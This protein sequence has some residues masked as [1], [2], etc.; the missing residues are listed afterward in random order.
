ML[1]YLDPNDENQLCIGYSVCHKNDRFDYR[2][3]FHLNGIGIQFAINKADKHKTSS[4]FII[5]TR[6]EDRQLPKTIV[7]I[8]QSI[9][10]SLRHF[11]Y[12]C[13][14][15]KMYAGKQFP[16]WA[17]NFANPDFGPYKEPELLDEVA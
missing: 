17:I 9:A 7:K 1:A 6:T 11:I 10:E 3:G 8:P 15:F 12:R 16:E 5:S 14:R 2:K 13:S 4:D